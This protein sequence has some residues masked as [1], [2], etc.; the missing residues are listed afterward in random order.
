MSVISHLNRLPCDPELGEP[1]RWTEKIISWKLFLSL[2][3]KTRLFSVKGSSDHV[4]L[5]GNGAGEQPGL[6]KIYVPEN[7]PLSFWHQSAMKGFV[8]MRL[9]SDL[10]LQLARKKLKDVPEEN[11]LKERLSVQAW[12]SDLKP[13]GKARCG[14]LSL[15][16]Q[17]HR[18]S[19]WI[20][21]MPIQVQVHWENLSQMSK[22]K[23][24]W[25]R[26]TVSSLSFQKARK[27]KH[28]SIHTST[29]S[30]HTHTHTHTHTTKYK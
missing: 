12:G 6:Y 21:W 4:S 24:N 30:G 23:S 25:V 28:S 1:G 9:S 8:G 15:Q 26:G 18:G 13:T 2:I 17:H 14:C 7:R 27:G 5:V 22:A 10:I 16:P 20:R 29:Y 11:E 19:L 3:W